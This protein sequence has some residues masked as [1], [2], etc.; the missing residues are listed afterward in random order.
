MDL[1][2]LAVVGSLFLGLIVGDAALLGNSLYV[3][4]ALP[5]S[6]TDGGF[7]RTTAEEIFVAE[8][9][10]YTQ[11]ASLIAT[12]SVMTSSAPGLPMALA[13]PLQLEDVVYSIQAAVRPY[14]VVNVTGSILA[15]D[16]K[17]GLKIYLVV[18]NPP[19]PPLA[20]S[21]QQADGNPQA[22]I[23][24]AARE[25]M[26][27]IAPYRVAITDFQQGIDGDPKAFDRSRESV[28]KGL[29]QAWDPRTEGA[30]ETAL[31]L[32]LRGELA[33]LDGN[34]TEADKQFALAAT[35]PGATPA[36]YGLIAFNRAFGAIAQRQPAEAARYYRQGMERVTTLS[37][38]DVHSR[39]KVMACLVDW[40]AGQPRAAEQC[41][42]DALT[43]SDDDPLP[44]LYLADLLAARG[45]T[46][47]AAAEQK[48]AEEVRRYDPKFPALLTTIFQLDPVHGGY[49][50]I[51]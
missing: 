29:A 32:N 14:G 43:L 44:H 36:A 28:A 7:S 47:G 13:R 27:A 34:V 33:I 21:L 39:V 4:M 48:M 23:E 51:F 17:P 40:S 9:N 42:R 46:A 25:T 12:P 16:Q 37:R 6:L 41:F 2:T 38:A 45:D 20:L 18:R 22:L 24:H 5:N 1:T 19:D 50:P 11:L 31:L 30:T 15:E 8:I 35:I 26:T 10:R 3:T 49:K